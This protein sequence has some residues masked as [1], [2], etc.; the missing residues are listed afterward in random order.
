MNISDKALAAITKNI[1]RALSKGAKLNVIAATIED[2]LNKHPSVGL[3][4]SEHFPVVN[5]VRLT[6]GN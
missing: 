2:E 3:A 5:G 4:P 1:K 6:N